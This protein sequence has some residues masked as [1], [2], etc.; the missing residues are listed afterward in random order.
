MSAAGQ[1][2]AFQ[3]EQG[4][5]DPEKS[6]TPNIPLSRPILHNRTG[7][8]NTGLSTDFDNRSMLPAV[9]TSPSITNG[10]LNGAE[11]QLSVS[12]TDTN[13][14]NEFVTH[15]AYS[16]DEN[17]DATRDSFV[18]RLV[19]QKLKLD[20]GD[21]MDKIDN[22]IKRQVTRAAAPPLPPNGGA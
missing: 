22:M 10:V 19:P 14:D 16:E 4:W 7:I 2:L 6:R 8:Q 15:D 9:T 1:L 11:H 12:F 21:T 17:D 13:S 20:T 18:S 3:K 5:A